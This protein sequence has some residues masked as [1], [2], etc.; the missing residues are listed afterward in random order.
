M[1][2]AICIALTRS[3]PCSGRSDVTR[4]SARR[5]V[6]ASGGSHTFGAK[7]ATPIA[8]DVTDATG[9]GITVTHT[10]SPSIASERGM[11]SRSIVRRTRVVSA[12]TWVS[13]P[14]I[15][16]ATQTPVRGDGEVGDARRELGRADR[17]GAP[18]ADPPERSVRGHRDPRRIPADGDRSDEIRE[19][20]T[21]VA[22]RGLNARPAARPHR[23]R[24]PPRHR[25]LPSRPPPRARHESSP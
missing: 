2:C 16:F 3:P 8:S 13:V 20:W 18:C 24:R 4:K 7:V 23:R 10:V 11:P 14:A 5:R 22:R 19:E 17:L 21:P 1:A 25:R 15:G 9:S 6:S 12:S